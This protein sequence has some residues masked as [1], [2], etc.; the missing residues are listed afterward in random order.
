MIIRITKPAKV[1]AMGMGKVNVLPYE[2][3][4][5]VVITV[6]E[7]YYEVEVKKESKT[8]SLPLESCCAISQVVEQLAARINLLREEL[9]LHGDLAKRLM[10]IMWSSAAS[11]EQ[12]Q[13]AQDII[14]R[15]IINRSIQEHMDDNGQADKT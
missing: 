2:L 15:L 11:S 6:P 9:D 4:A 5:G 12:L 10:D 8:S 13:G 14:N 7:G 1:T 3:P